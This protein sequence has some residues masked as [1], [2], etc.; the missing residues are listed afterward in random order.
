MRPHALPRR[1]TLQAGIP[2]KVSQSRHGALLMGLSLTA[3]RLAVKHHATCNELFAQL[4][5]FEQFTS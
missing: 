3:E 1:W 2:M 5:S 4:R